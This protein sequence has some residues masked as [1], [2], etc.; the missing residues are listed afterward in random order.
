MG[1]TTLVPSL[2]LLLCLLLLLQLQLPLRFDHLLILP[3][4][5]EKLMGL[6]AS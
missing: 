4:I 6:K 1:G 3:S 2:L 5:S